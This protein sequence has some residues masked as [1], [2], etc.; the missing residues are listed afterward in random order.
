MLIM[1]LKICWKQHTCIYQR[2]KTRVYGR[3]LV[4]IAGSNPVGGMDVCVL[5][6]FCVLR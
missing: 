1:H 6:M 4:E 5:C 2:S 3:S